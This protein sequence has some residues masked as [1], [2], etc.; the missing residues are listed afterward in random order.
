[1]VQFLNYFTE[2]SRLVQLWGL[3]EH[4]LLKWQSMT[5]G[6]WEGNTLNFINVLSNISVYKT[7]L[8]MSGY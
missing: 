3:P 8:Y 6:S 5:L 2:N 1:M 4:L 7:I